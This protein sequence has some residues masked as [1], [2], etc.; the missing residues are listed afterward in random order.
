[1]LVGRNQH[2]TT[3]SDVTP[4][5]SPPRGERTPRAAAPRLSIIKWRRTGGAKGKLKEIAKTQVKYCPPTH[6]W[7]IIIIAII[8]VSLFREPLEVPPV[9]DAPRDGQL[10]NPFCIY[11]SRA[12]IIEVIMGINK[13][14]Y[15][16][17]RF[18][19]SGGK[20]SLVG[21]DNNSSAIRAQTQTEY[22]IQSS[23]DQE[24]APHSESHLTAAA[25]ALSPNQQQLCCYLKEPQLTWSVKFL[26]L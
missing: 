26:C 9:A 15:Q 17:E 20:A 11:N 4:N 22:K 24:R 23:S 13:F 21:Q 7:I 2:Q 8:Q 18:A 19:T 5:W 6:S 1:M 25:V 10:A 16:T 12:L 3:T 14:N